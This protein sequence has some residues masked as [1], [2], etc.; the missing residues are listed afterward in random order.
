[1]D[2]TNVWNFTF[3]W[4]CNFWL[5][6]KHHKQNAPEP[7]YTVNPGWECWFKCVFAISKHPETHHLPDH[8]NC[9]SNTETKVFC[10]IFKRILFYA[11]VWMVVPI[12]LQT[13]VQY[14]ILDNFHSLCYGSF[15]VSSPLPSSES[16]WFVPEFSWVNWLSTKYHQESLISG[17]CL[18]E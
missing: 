8:I 16:S 14:E 7:M 2:S 1:M 3:F 11:Y 4:Q 12:I 17:S 13:L 18:N 15:V 9:L 5:T 10:G 6:F